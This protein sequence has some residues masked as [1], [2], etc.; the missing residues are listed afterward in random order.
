M[1]G[2]LIRGMALDLAVAAVRH[3]DPPV[4]EESVRLFWNL[5]TFTDRRVPDPRVPAPQFGSAAR[6]PARRKAPSP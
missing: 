6:S 3:P 1:I 5:Q 2:Q 4:R